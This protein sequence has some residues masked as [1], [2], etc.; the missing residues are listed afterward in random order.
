[1]EDNLIQATKVKLGW[2]E[3]KTLFDK[4]KDDLESRQVLIIELKYIHTS[5]ITH[6]QTTTYESWKLA[7]TRVLT[8]MS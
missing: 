3:K 1:M 5:N 2:Q 8:H 6:K 4:M 7:T